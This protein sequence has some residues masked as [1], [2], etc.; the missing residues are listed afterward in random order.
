MFLHNP[1]ESI[2]LDVEWENG[3]PSDVSCVQGLLQVCCCDM[4][5]RANISICCAYVHEVGDKLDTPVAI[6]DEN[7]V[8]LQQLQKQPWMQ[9]PM[10]KA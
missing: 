5:D 10:S 4:L 2:Q 8:Q 1:G 7:H 6:D 3:N 9:T